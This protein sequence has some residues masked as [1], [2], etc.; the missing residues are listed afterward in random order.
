MQYQIEY[1]ESR[2]QFC[3]ECGRDVGE[4]ETAI[5]QLL[6]NPQK[7]DALFIASDRLSTASIR[8]LNK[9]PD[10]NEI[11]IIGFVN[12]DVID[13]LSPRISYVRQRAF[14]MGQIAA[15]ML[16]KLIESKLPVY[17]F[18]TEYLDADIHWLC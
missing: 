16:I 18:N 6:N 13:L 14:E 10:L 1:D 8:A 3:K 17:Q 7:P 2:V 11:A 9:I 15:N 12:S 5:N 4:V